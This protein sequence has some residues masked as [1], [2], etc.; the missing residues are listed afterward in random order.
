VDD[1]FKWY[2]VRVCVGD[3]APYGMNMTVVNAIDDAITHAVEF[4]GWLDNGTIWIESG[5][6][7][8]NTEAA[9]SRSLDEICALK[10]EVATL[11][12]QM[13]MKEEGEWFK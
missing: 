6:S 12:Q 2:E 9:Y 5:P 11:K 13:Y 7:D 8:H 10:K 1:E 3:D 4:S